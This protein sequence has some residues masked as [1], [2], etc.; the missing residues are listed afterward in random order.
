MSVQLTQFFQTPGADASP[1]TFSIAGNVLLRHIFF[2][3]D[4]I[5]INA[6]TDF[7]DVT[8][9]DEDD[10]VLLALPLALSSNVSPDMPLT[11]PGGGILFKGSC[12]VTIPGTSKIRI[13]SFSLLYEAGG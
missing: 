11:I 1:Q 13:R 4:A 7:I 10:E 2:T 9:K 3:P 8:F 12:S 5:D 6:A